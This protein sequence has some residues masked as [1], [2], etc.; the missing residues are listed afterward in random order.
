MVQK[1]T[2]TNGMRAAYQER[3]S[4]REREREF[5]QV[6]E[7]E[8]RGKRKRLCIIEIRLVNAIMM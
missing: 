4:E 6:R 7:R 1:S 3:E 8:R 5:S 2:R